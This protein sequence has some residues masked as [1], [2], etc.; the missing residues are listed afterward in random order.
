LD[1]G[2]DLEAGDELRPAVAGRVSPRRRTGAFDA[3]KHLGA[4]L[5]NAD[6]TGH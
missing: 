4:A 1:D 5:K 6:G 3:A 2:V